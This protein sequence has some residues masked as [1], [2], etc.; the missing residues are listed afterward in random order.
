MLQFDWKKYIKFGE[1]NRN[2]NV[3]SIVANS[4][5]WHGV[6]NI[7]LSNVVVMNEPAAASS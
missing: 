1:A 4:N 6:F 2:F 5:V 7:I 3:F